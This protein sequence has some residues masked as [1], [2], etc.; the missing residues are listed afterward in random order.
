LDLKTYLNMSLDLKESKLRL[1]EPKFSKQD[2]KDKIAS[3][4]Q[5]NKKEKK[6]AEIV[7]F[8]VF[9]VQNALIKFDQIFNAN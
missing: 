6:E 8:G 1:S 3:I 4:R 9:G 2:I 7:D 5:S